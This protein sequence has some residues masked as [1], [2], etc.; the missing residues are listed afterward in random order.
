VA[1][2]RHLNRLATEIH[3][4]PLSFDP[5]VAIQLGAMFGKAAMRDVQNRA[6]LSCL[7]PTWPLSVGPDQPSDNV[8]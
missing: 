8:S 6:F 2:V 5:D 4:A 7:F 3:Y 1:P